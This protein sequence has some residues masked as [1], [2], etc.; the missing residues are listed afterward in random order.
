[1]LTLHIAPV[2]KA[3]GIDKPFSFMVKNGMTPHSAHKL[4]SGTL[5]VIRLDHVE[6]LCRILV[7]E[8][9]DLLYWSPSGQ[10]KLPASHPLTQLKQAGFDTNWKET[11]ASVPLHQ[12]KEITSNMVK[13]SGE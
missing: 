1:M 7:C 4:L 9:N 12:L 11:L 10:E 5:R 3:R 2:F 6:F 13:Q 8:P